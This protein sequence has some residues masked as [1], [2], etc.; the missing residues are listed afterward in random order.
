MSVNGKS[1]GSTFERKIANLLSARFENTL[2][3]KQSFRRNPD[4]GSFFGG[5]NHSRT[6]SHS[7]DYAIFGDL[8]C[9]R[10]FTY[11]IEC[12]HY[13]TPPSFQSVLN[14]TVTQWDQWLAQAQQDAAGSKKQM[15]L[16]I[17]YNN[18]DV[19]VFLKEAIPGKYHN[20]YKDFHIHLLDDWLAQPDDHFLLSNL[21]DH[22]TTHNAVVQSEVTHGYETHS[23]Q[24][25]PKHR[26]TVSSS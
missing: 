14:H 8:I 21:T 13:K 24:E 2:G 26:D 18:V 22:S 20:K 11:S 4:S 25:G 9:P 17:K 1:K 23:S 15:S 6:T 3:I 16:I 19:M 12:K 10:N 7:L 5:Q